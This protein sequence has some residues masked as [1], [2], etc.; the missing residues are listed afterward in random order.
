MAGFI[1]QQASAAQLLPC[2]RAS[3]KAFT[4]GPVRC[5]GPAVRRSVTCSASPE[6]TAG[7]RQIL[8]LA[9]VAGLTAVLPAP[10]QAAKKGGFVPVNDQGD[11]YRLLYPFGWQEV[12]VTG[13]DVVYKD[14]IEPLE[15]VSVNMVPTD[16]E[17]ITLFGTPEEVATTLAENVLTSPNQAV[18]VLLVKPYAVEG[19]NYVLFEFAANSGNY[20]RRAIAVVTIANGKLYTLVTGANEKRYA[21]MKGKLETVAQSFVVSTKYT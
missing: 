17:D 9:G 14:I 10:A 15:S 5:T 13:Q 4:A 6:A 3:V 19:R 18:K 16:K 12:S 1:A 21:K 7:R 8:Q 11:A 2:T 20:I